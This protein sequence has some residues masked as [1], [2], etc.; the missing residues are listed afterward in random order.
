MLKLIQ[1]CQVLLLI[2]VDKINKSSERSSMVV[3]DVLRIACANQKRGKEVNT[4]SSF[5]LCALV[6]NK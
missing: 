6:E 3:N 2:K 5:M 1:L 4:I